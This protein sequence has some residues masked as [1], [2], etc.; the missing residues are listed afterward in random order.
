MSRISRQPIPTRGLS[1]SL[2]GQRVI[3]E[4]AKGK[5]EFSVHPDVGIE[6][7]DDSSLAVS[8]RAEG[9]KAL[10]GTMRSLVNNFLIG[11]DQG[12]SKRLVLRGVGFRAQ[13]RGRELDL[14][15]NYSHPV[16]YSVPEDVQVEVPT[17]TEIVIKGEDKQ[18]VGQ[19]AAIIRSFRR[20]DA[21]KGKGVSY[22][23]EVIVL[24]EGKK[25][26]A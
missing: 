19:V 17:P 16:N 25:K 21:Y 13:L 3:A 6:R 4:T 8:E 11:L 18:R 2:E 1:V 7:L 23:D 26:K 24:K 12:F 14:S 9:S 10:A 5:R 20:P 15:L 22:Q